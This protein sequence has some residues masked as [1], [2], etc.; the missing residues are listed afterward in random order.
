MIRSIDSQQ[1]SASDERVSAAT[2]ASS[3][4]WLSH[5]AEERLIDLIRQTLS[6]LMAPQMAPLA[7]EY[8]TK[9]DVATLLKVSRRTVESYLA[10]GLL[11]YLRIGGVIRIRAKDLESHLMSSFRIAPR[12]A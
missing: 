2:A 10:R 6:E 4:P 5:A 11:P 1:T 8:L 3:V 9:D 7:N 12:K